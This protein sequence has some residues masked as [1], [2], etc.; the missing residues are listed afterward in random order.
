MVNAIDR[1][2]EAAERQGL[3]MGNIELDCL[4]G[5]IVGSSS[6][7]EEKK[8]HV[9]FEDL[10]VAPHGFDSFSSAFKCWELS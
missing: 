1:T 6:D 8:N 4:Q 5:H 10:Y 7:E 2:Y 3:N 9:P